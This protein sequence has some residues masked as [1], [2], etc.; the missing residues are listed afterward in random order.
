MDDMLQAFQNIPTT[1]A[2]DASNGLNNLDPSI[3]PLKETYQMAGRAFTVKL[4]A[5]DNLAVL[6][7]IKEAQPGDILVVDAQGEQYRAIAGDFV[8]GMMQTMG[9][10]GL[11]VDGVIRDISDIKALDF[12]VFCKGTTVASSGKTGVG[13]VNETIA[14]GGVSVQPGDLIIGDADGVVV[15]PQSTEQDVLDKATEKIAKDNDRDEKV[16]GK[17]EEI[18]AYIDRMLK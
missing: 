6:K 15:V 13:D 5:G 8:A 12:P 1:S 7:A 14:C 9:L 17:P 16:S 2:S 3:K 10:G 18:H 11:V 4:P